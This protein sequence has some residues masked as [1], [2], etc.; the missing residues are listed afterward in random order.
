MTDAH[1]FNY[2]EEISL[3]TYPHISLNQSAL[4]EL[5]ATAGME[6]RSCR[7]PWNSAWQHAEP[8]LPAPLRAFTGK[9]LKEI[10]LYCFLEFTFSGMNCWIS[11][12]NHLWPLAANKSMSNEPEPFRVARKEMV[13]RSP[14]PLHQQVWE[15]YLQQM[16][17]QFASPISE[18]CAG[19]NMSYIYVA[20]LCFTGFS[21][22]HIHLVSQESL[23][24]KDL[25]I[26]FFSL[27]I[28]VH[29]KLQGNSHYLI[30]LLNS[31]GSPSSS[32][33]KSD[34]QTDA[35]FKNRIYKYM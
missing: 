7:G 15:G 3:W 26:E 19:K 9:D 5:P 32:I 18:F 10:V 4:E 25:H 21:T 8:L 28:K 27:C 35:E 33:K 30:H 2:E 6:G 11:R 16:L 1:I 12:F 22:D 29:L 20:Q 23:S 13:C 24:R 14:W 34:K 31:H 17:E